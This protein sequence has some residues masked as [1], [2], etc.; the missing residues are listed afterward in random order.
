MQEIQEYLGQLEQTR[1][2]LADSKKAVKDIQDVEEGSEVLAPLGSGAY[3]VAEIKE[4]DKVITNIG[5]DVFEERG[6]ES[7]AKVIQKQLT[8]LKDTQ[9]EL[10]SQ[11]N[12]I[13]E[14]MQQI[15]QKMQQQQE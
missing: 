11:M 9:N 10:E 7:A 15:Q 5:G 8:L 14:E 12:E 3:V 1:Q 13:Q 6:N 2:E 4:T